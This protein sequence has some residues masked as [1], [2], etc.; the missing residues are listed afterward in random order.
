MQI[1]LKP[2]FDEALAPF[3]EEAAAFFLAAGL[4]HA[5]RISFA[6]AADL[7]NLSFED[8]LF[9]LREHFGSGF[10]MADASVQEDLDTVDSF[11]ATP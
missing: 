5:H 11:A 3:G 7:A 8:F 2:E 1:H 10:N 6:A 4:Y 9:R